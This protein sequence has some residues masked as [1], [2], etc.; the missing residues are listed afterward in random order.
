[1]LLKSEGEPRSIEIRCTGNKC[2]KIN[3][4]VNPEIVGLGKTTVGII[5]EAPYVDEVAYDDGNIKGRPFVGR[6]GMM[7]REYFDYEKY[8]YHIVNSINCLT[9]EYETTVKPSEMTVRERMQRIEA[10]RPFVNEIFDYLDNGSVIMALGVFARLSLF[11]EKVGVSPFPKEY[12]IGEKKFYV[13][14]NH[15]PAYLI[16]NQSVKGEFEDIL[17][18]SGVFKIADESADEI[19]KPIS[20]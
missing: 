16:Y 5:G 14:V 11:N 19:Q 17:E 18:A 9:Y 1:M 3:A 20:F 6:S 7:L 13:F 4:V 2:H 10:C 15:H 8:T 12:K